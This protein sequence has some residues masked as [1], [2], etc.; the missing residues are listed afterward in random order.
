MFSQITKAQAIKIELQ[1]MLAVNEN[2]EYEIMMNKLEDAWLA[3]VKNNTFIEFM[4][5][6]YHRAASEQS[7]P[8]Q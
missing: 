7:L 6:E 8:H 2:Y 1:Q 4:D 5:D 3:D